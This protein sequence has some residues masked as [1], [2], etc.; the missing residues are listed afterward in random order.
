M[1]T[2][3]LIL[4]GHEVIGEKGET[5]LEVAKKNSVRIPHLCHLKLGDI[6]TN[7]C[8]SCRMCVVEVDKRDGL[9]PA[10]STKIWEGMNVVT[11]SAEI[12]NI[13]R[14]ILE[15]ILANHPKEC[16]TCEKS[17]DCELQKLAEEF[18]IRDIRYEEELKGLKKEVSPAIIRDMNKCIMCR[19]CETMCNKIQT[20]NILSGI[21]RGAKAIVSTAY[22]K[23]LTETFCTF[24]GQCV[25]VCPVGAL[26]ERNY[27]WDVNKEIANPKKIV[28]AQIAPAVRVAL[29]EEFGI[30]IGTNIEKKIVT[31]LKKLG[32]DY[33]FDTTWAADLTIMEEATEFKE[34]V[35]KYLKGDKD[36]KLPLLTSCCP[37]WMNFIEANFPELKGMPSTAKSPQQ[38]CSSVIKN[39]WSKEKNINKKD[40]V[41]VS[42]MPCLAKKYEAQRDEFKDEGV[43]DTDFS[44]TTRELAHMIKASDIDFKTI[45][46]SEFDSP[47]GNYSGAG[48]IFGRT[49][50]VIEAATRTAYKLIT[51]EE[52]YDLNFTNMYGEKGTRIAEVLIAGAKIRI[53]ITHG[54]G[55]ARKLLEKVKSGE[56]FLHGVEIMACKSG[57]VGGGGQPYTHGDYNIILKRAKAINSIDK[58]GI[59]R[60][61]HENPDIIKIYENY[62]GEPLSQKALSLLHIHKK[63]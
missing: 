36:V 47:M 23:N 61:S 33:V 30:E 10:C 39:I 62:L 34:R 11:N 50:G 46:D 4:N 16:L 43:P 48:I 15:L 25:A 32:F 40:I 21:N 27:T 24:C 3:K 53:G 44:I 59:I 31:A 52:L 7:E 55:E 13:R 9:Y 22:N 1:K 38:M 18:R 58:N 28:V 5:I 20:C 26:T 14:D 19:R 54:L 2:V 51:G 49:G 60:K 35:L 57:C 29:G 45:G 6:Y 17:G 8:A 37:A 42:I 12:Q 63:K 56:E 41:V